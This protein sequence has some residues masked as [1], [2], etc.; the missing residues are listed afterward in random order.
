[1]PKQTNNEYIKFLEFFYLI[2]IVFEL[3]S[4]LLRTQS[5]DTVVHSIHMYAQKSAYYLQNIFKNTGMNI[6][7]G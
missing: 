6:G 2:G 1:M 5:I 7:H 4:F 3:F